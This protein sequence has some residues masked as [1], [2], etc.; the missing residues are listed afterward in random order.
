M[1]KIFKLEIEKGPG[2][3]APEIGI[4]ANI[5]I[6]DAGGSI[7]QGSAVIIPKSSSYKDL[8]R[9]ISLV[10]EGLD[11]LLDRSREIFG[12]NLNGDREEQDVNEEMSSDEIWDILSGISDFDR[13]AAKFNGLSRQKRLEVADYVFSHGEIF[14]GPPAKFSM[15]YNCEKGLI[16]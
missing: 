1:E 9:K 6:R 14:S 13:A 5:G 12:K 16:E 3:D 11:E 15:R 8:E 2:K 4:S 7:L 10:K